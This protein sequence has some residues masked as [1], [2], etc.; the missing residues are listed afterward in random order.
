MRRAPSKRHRGQPGRGG[1]SS[2]RGWAAVPRSESS[3]TLTA[4]TYTARGKFPNTGPSEPAGALVRRLRR[5]G[6]PLGRRDVAIRG[7]RADR[8][9]GSGLQ[10]GRR[11]EQ[12][13]LVRAG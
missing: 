13:V 8:C 9:S 1:S 12:V 7:E 11:C 3:L 5:L 6:Q 2:T 10:I 4:A